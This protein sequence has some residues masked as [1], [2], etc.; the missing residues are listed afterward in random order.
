MVYEHL[1]KNGRKYDNL[2]QFVFNE[3]EKLGLSVSGLSKKCNLSEDVISNIE[4]GLETFLPTT[5]RQKLAKGLKV[6]LDEI[7]L[8]EKLRQRSS[9][10]IRE[11]L[12]ND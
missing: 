1:K 2:A 5:I 10:N 9:H 4:Q 3:R 12:L 8:Y 7:K 6:S 11:N